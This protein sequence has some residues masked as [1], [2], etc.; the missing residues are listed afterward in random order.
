[1]KTLQT[2]VLATLLSGAAAGLAHAQMGADKMS[3]MK[4][5]APAP[6]PAAMTDGEVRGIDKAHGKVTLRH[7]EIKNV[8]MP[9]MTMAYAVSDPQSLDALKDGDKV[10]FAMEKING[11]YTVTKIAPAK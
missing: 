7:G 11:I 2:L 1:M 6:N 8:G 3:G 9:G 5:D 4:M 10:R